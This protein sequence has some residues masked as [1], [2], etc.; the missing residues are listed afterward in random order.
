MAD[1]RHHIKVY[2]YPN[3]LTEDA[4]DYI[5][6]VKAERPLNIREIA[7]S[8]AGRGGA[9]ISADAI[10]QGLLLGLKEAAWL[11]CDG[12]SVNLDYFHGSAHINGVFHSPED[13]FDP[14]KHSLGFR[15]VQG[16]RL[17]AEATSID[18]DILG[19]APGGLHISQVIDAKTGS[20]NNKITAKYVLRILGHQLK[21]AGSNPA[22]GVY[23]VNVTTKAEVKIEPR[24]IVTN[25]P[26]EL[27][28][29][30]PDAPLGDY[31]L[32]LVSQATTGTHLLHEPRTEL[33]GTVL[34]LDE[35]HPS[36]G[37]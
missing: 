8:A 12:F 2:L 13:H 28:V 35:H 16:A 31:Q 19:I 20:V 9:N 11:M 27:L 3:A 14:E 33:F 23:F 32:K 1:V 34:T 15:F 30:I 4:N 24:D 36:T 10:Y 22:V 6:R 25:T 37:E 5:A 17:R 26:S 29:M 7:E 21:I 18:V